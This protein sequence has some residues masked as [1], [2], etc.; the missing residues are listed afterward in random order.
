VRMQ[1]VCAGSDERLLLEYVTRQKGED[2]DKIHSLCVIV[3]CEVWQRVGD[4]SN[5]SY[6]QSTPRLWY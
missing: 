2:R 5:E 1:P 3:I 6:C 4:D